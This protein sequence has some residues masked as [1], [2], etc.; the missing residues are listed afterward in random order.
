M[1]NASLRKYSKQ[2]LPAP[3][4]SPSAKNLKMKKS[5]L[6]QCTVS[7]QVSSGYPIS[8]PFAL[9]TEG[10]AMID[11]LSNLSPEDN[12]HSSVVNGAPV[13]LFAD[14]ENPIDKLVGVVVTIFQESSYDEMFREV[15]PTTVPGE[16]VST[17]A[18]TCMD[19]KLL[20][21][22]LAAVVPIPEDQT[23]WRLMV[24][25]I[26]QVPAD[27]V[28]FNWECCSGCGDHQFPCSHDAGVGMREWCVEC[29]SSPCGQQD[30][31][32]R[33]HTEG[34]EE[35][36]T[37]Q[38]MSLALKRG[39]TVMCSDFSLKSLIF[40]WSEAHLGPN[41]F[42]KV[43]ECDRQFQLE[44]V[45]ADL[46]HEDVPQQLQVV[47]ELC[48]DKGKAV[49]SAMPS[50]ILYTVN[51]QRPK[52]S[53]YDLKVLTVVTETHSPIARRSFE[54]SHAG[55]LAEDMKCSI[56]KGGDL[57]KGAA[58]HVTLTYATGGQLITSM[59][60]WIELT[61]IN[62]SLESVLRVAAHEFGDEEV[63]AFDREY[64]S[65]C[66]DNERFE[67][68]QKYASSMVQKSVPSRMKARTKYSS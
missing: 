55:P 35:S 63:R 67:C 28:V 56:G 4:Q 19:V 62:T 59:G 10:D 9:G 39:H 17:Y 16:R 23:T 44:F 48:K 57:R 29:P 38:F 27:S 24:T 14:K 41:P 30:H 34:G 68:V 5:M 37:M 66:T 11:Q 52:T 49:V 61:R 6:K 58:G 21:D 2:K 26:Q 18:M 3:A 8:D 40:E 51:P 22:Y 43:G 54:G 33:P 12:N 31:Q 53:V 42:V 50:T 20:H 15:R 60:H 36:E 46:Q 64:A 1:G 7:K 13:K 25:E 47:G 32:E 45:P 65:K